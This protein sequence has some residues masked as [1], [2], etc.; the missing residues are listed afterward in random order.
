MIRSVKVLVSL[1]A[2]LITPSLQAEP[3][4]N[5]AEAVEYRQNA[6]SMIRANFGVLAVWFVTKSPS[7]QTKQKRALK[8]CIIYRIYLG[9]VL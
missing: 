8:R 9:K 3:F 6:F 7:M 1:G 2:L 4:E 5:A